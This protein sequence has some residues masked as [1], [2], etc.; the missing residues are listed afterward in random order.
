MG[1]EPTVVDDDEVKYVISSPSSE[2]NVN[3]VCFCQQFAD[4]LIHFHGVYV[5]G[6]DIS[7][8]K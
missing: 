6:V 5:G 7:L 2:R 1:D 3:Y 4:L 8:V